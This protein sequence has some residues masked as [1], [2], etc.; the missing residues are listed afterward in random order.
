MKK[1]PT[2]TNNQWNLVQELETVEKGLKLKEGFF[3][4]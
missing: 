4:C 1:T 2:K 3:V